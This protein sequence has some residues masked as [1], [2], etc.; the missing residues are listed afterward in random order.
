MIVKYRIHRQLT[1][2][3]SSVREQRIAH[4]HELLIRVNQLM[5]LTTE[6][7][8]LFQ[9]VC[10]LI[11]EYGK[12]RIASIAMPKEDGSVWHFGIAGEKEYLEHAFISVD[13]NVPEGKGPLG[14]S[15]REDRAVY[16]PSFQD[17]KNMAPWVEQ[18]EHYGIQSSASIPI[19]RKGKMWGILTIYHRDAYIFD[20]AMMVL[21]E[22]LALDISNGIDRIDLEEMYRHYTEHT[23]LGMAIMMQDR[24]VSVNQRLVKMLGYL[25]E[26]EL[27]GH[28]LRILFPVDAERD[29]LLYWHDALQHLDEM[30][31]LGF[32]MM[33]KDG[34]R[35]WVEVSISVLNDQYYPSD[36]LA[37]WTI[38][39]V[40]ERYRL[41]QKLEHA[42]MY[43]A[44]TE[45]PNRMALEIYMQEVLQQA[46]N[47][48]FSVIV[49]LID[50][51]NFKWV[52]DT[53]GHEVGDRV[54][55]EF[56]CR[57][58]A[59]LGAVDF[60]ARWGGDEFVV[61]FQHEEKIPQQDS[62]SSRLE[63]MHQAV[64]YPIE[65]APGHEV[66]VEM[67]MGLSAYPMHGEDS[68]HLVRLADIAM[69]QVKN[70]KWSRNTWWQWGID[71]MITG[72]PLPM[73]SFPISE[74]VDAFFERMNMDPVALSIFHSLSEEDYQELKGNA[75]KHLEFLLHARSSD[76]EIHQRA[77][78]IGEIHALVGVSGQIISQSMEH[79]SKVIAEIVNNQSVTIRYALYSLLQHRLQKDQQIQLQTIEQTMLTYLEILPL[80]L[81]SANWQEDL[82]IVAQLPGIIG[83]LLIRMHPQEGFVVE[84]ALGSKGKQIADVMMASVTRAIPFLVGQQGQSL[85]AEAWFSAMIQS[86]PSY[87]NDQRLQIRQEAFRQL[88][89]RSV[90]AVPLLDEYHHTVAVIELVGIYPNQ[91]ES[92]WMKVFMQGLQRWGEERWAHQQV[93]STA[94]DNEK[95]KVYRS[96]LYSG[97]FALYMQPIVDLKTGH[98]LKFEGLA[99]L[100][101]E[102]GELVH[103]GQFLPTLG[104]TE[105]ERLFQLGFEEAVK[106]LSEWR[107]SKN[108]SKISINLSP[109]TLMRSD[110]VS[111]IQK[112]LKRYQCHPE[113]VILELLET[114]GDDLGD[115]ESVLKQLV[116]LGIPLAID[117][118]GSGDSNF[119]RLATFPI[120]MVKL[121]RG[122]FAP[123]HE[124]P[125]SVLNFLGSLIQ[126]GNDFGWEIVVEGL[127]TFEMVEAVFML[128]ARY[129]Q[130]FYFAKPIS[131]EQ[132]M[133]WKSAFSFTMLS[134]NTI[135]T[136]LGALAYLIRSVRNSRYNM[137]S[138]VDCPITKFF[139]A[140]GW[141][142]SEGT[143]LHHQIH[144]GIKDSSTYKQLLDWMENQI[145]KENSLLAGLG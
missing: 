28:S 44:L 133:D 41:Q 27:I 20:E 38:Q 16:N 12:F 103:P 93:K 53:Y 18:A 91:F 86:T 42:A 55:K 80:S 52:N 57:L 15:W 54:L 36:D 61:V 94:D 131:K 26:K 104:E 105:L 32:A 100:N 24:I 71:E 1:M 49:G 30:Q 4:F 23:S 111:W 39:E 70:T 51:D 78:R 5:V 8:T 136:S 97:G 96:L 101:D 72:A 58:Q 43:D 106:Q 69:Y 33:Q 11:V 128:G 19:H 108:H 77:I 46:K 62:F 47:W 64:E 3:S 84:E 59:Y 29:P 45:L 126:I 83:V 87:M 116:D 107:E 134:K 17:Y 109:A 119:L 130:G 123:V 40:T 67:S 137:P 127:E 60:L 48:Q 21:F 129:G 35:I 25:N 115:I 140:R 66:T 125:Q 120:Q 89:V 98:V 114:P 145:R 102:N 135:H 82:G 50:L 143:A 73:V 7:S 10:N 99:R 112:I 110:L 75:K 81:S 90:A 124:N 34:Q 9:E 144:E 92:K 68:D 88:G 132:V 79:F 22:T 141:D 117:D 113:S 31:P 37:I 13:P 76:E 95:M 74:M 6:L 14:T 63:T 142:D 2:T 139:I 138:E 121:D 85:I 118:F 56:S 65:V 122:L